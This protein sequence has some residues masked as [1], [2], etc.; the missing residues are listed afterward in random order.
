MEPSLK[1]LLTPTQI[2]ATLERAGF[3]RNF[4]NKALPEIF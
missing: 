1:Y 3:S 2:E 4:G